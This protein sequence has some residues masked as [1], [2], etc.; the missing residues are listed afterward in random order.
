MADTKYSLLDTSIQEVDETGNYRFDREQ[1]ARIL[2]DNLDSMQVSEGNH[3]PL[4]TDISVCCSDNVV[5]PFHSVVLAACSS[6]IK[7][8][9]AS[10]NFAKYANGEFVI[11]DVTSIGVDVL[12]DFAYGCDV[13]VTDDNVEE[14]RKLATLY[15][16]DDL[17]SACEVRKRGFH[18]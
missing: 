2:L 8:T 3:K 10:E 9:L 13:I 11:R 14:V 6:T 16:I 12:R 5:V 7:D 18:V 1:H 15:N 17:E 4:L